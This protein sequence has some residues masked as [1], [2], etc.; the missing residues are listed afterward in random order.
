[1][2]NLK[3]VFLAYFEWKQR[4]TGLYKISNIN[5]NL[6]RSALV[7]N[8]T[9]LN[10]GKN[11]RMN[12]KW[13]LWEKKINEKCVSL[14]YFYNIEQKFIKINFQIE[15]DPIHLARLFWSFD[16]TIKD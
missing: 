15:I 8:E 5:K 4:L 14:S 6:K 9:F 2:A 3:K 16:L 12:F 11:I 10:H 1:M 7:F 13:P